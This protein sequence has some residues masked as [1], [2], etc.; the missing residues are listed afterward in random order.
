MGERE[1][2]PTI[3][4]GAMTGETGDLTAGEDEPFVPAERREAVDPELE[5]AMTQRQR[6]E[7][8]ARHPAESADMGPG[9]QGSAAGQLQTERASGLTGL[10][11]QSSMGFSV[12]PPPGTAAGAG[13]TELSQRQGG[14]GGEQGLAADDPA[15]RME[16]RPR[17]EGDEEREPPADSE[18]RP[19][20]DEFSMPDSEHL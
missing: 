6:A 18:V 11:G 9:A 17:P 8:D 19:G 1:T 2:Q 15:Y 10:Q 14:Y 12:T 5:G 4:G 3:G 7:A 20:V 13:A 16:E